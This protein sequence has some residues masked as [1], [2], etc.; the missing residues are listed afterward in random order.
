MKNIVPL[1]IAAVLLLNSAFAQ[2]TKAKKAAKK[3]Q[4]P[5]MDVITD[6]PKL[7]RVLLIGD[8]ISI[9]Y[10]V[11]VR[12]QMA[13]KANVHRI[14]TN[15]G[16]TTNGLKYL[17]SWLGT[18]KWDV[19][20][21]NWG[22]HDLK[23]LDTG[24]RQVPLDEYEK[25]LRELVTQ[26]KATGAQ[27]IWCSTTPVPDGDLN[28]PRKNED[29]IAYNVVAKKIM[30]ENGI[31]TDDLYAY[32]LPQISS[33]QLPKNV[34]YSATGYETLAKQVSQSLNA[35]LAKVPAK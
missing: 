4:D 18:G 1:L 20:H 19:I 22:L 11:P 14:L 12:K 34:H 29:V 23:F 9:G 15:G 8:S 5:A 3:K 21:F 24:K 32:A 10:T 35:A 33:I 25:N 7:P 13:G 17:K 30:D 27:L 2:E 31:V 28:P 6:D 16:P 26:L